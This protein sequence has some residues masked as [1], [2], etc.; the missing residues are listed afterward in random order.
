MIRQPVVAGIFYPGSKEAL[1]LAIEKCFKGSRGPGHVPEVR[2]EKPTTVISLIAPHAG[3]Q[4]SGEIAAH[5]YAVLAEDGTPDTVVLIGPNHTGIGAR[6][7]VSPHT[8]WRTPLGDVEVD[9]EL[10]ESI[11]SE[12]AYAELDEL[13]HER[14]H[15]IEVQLP[16]LQYLFDKQLKIVAITMLDQSL[17]AARDLAQALDNVMTPGE[18]VLI[19]TSDLSHYEPHD[20]AVKKDSEVIE[21]ILRLS[22][23]DIVDAARERGYTVCGYGA[24]ATAALYSS[25]RGVERGELLR[26]STSGEVTGE[27][28][29]V[30]GYAAIVYRRG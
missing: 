17:T 6:I 21:S 22:A 7:S 28:H 12:S 19:A 27:F 8:A 29:A 3:L 30:V 4:Y 10:A 9:K 25:R 13:A 5:S 26:Y 11:A 1:R 16:F 18:H 20:I 24:I 2:V 14:E 23:K 15:S